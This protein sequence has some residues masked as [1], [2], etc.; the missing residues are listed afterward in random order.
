MFLVGIIF[1]GNTNLIS[2]TLN[3]YLLFSTK[4]KN[5][6]MTPLHKFWKSV[7]A[8]TQQNTSKPSECCFECSVSTLHVNVKGEL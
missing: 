1:Q 6:F 8:K 4:K 5:V 3:L 7:M 2:T